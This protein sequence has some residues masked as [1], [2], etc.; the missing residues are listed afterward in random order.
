LI[1][2]FCHYLN[3]HWVRPMYESGRRDVYEIFTMAMEVWQLVFFQPLQSQVTLECLQLINDERQNEMI[4]TRLI[5]KVVQSYVELGFW[6]NSSVP[7]NSHQ[8]TSQTLVIY[9]DYFE[10]QFLQSTE[11]FY[12]QEAADFLVHNSVTEY[13]KKVFQRFEEEKHRVHSYLHSSTEKPL[14]KKLEDVFIRDQL[15]AI[16]IEAKALLHD[17]KYSG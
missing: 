6:E 13:L 17:E 2:G 8:I 15:E 11:E 16:Y 12:R 5:H 10:V 1:N 7:N 3:R 4:N 14:I 9:K